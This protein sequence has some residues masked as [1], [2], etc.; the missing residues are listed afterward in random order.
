MFACRGAVCASRAASRS[1]AR[2]WPVAVAD[3]ELGSRPRVEAA[4]AVALFAHSARMAARAATARRC[5]KAGSSQMCGEQ[6]GRVKRVRAFVDERVAASGAAGVVARG[7]RSRG[8]VR[9]RVEA[10]RSDRA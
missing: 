7:A 3:V 4:Q 5:D 8:R 9:G 1:G 2:T 10:A 6:H